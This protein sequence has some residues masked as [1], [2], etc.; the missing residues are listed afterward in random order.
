MLKVPNLKNISKKLWKELEKCWKKMLKKSFHSSKDFEAMKAGTGWAADILKIR[1]WMSHVW[2]S[3]RMRLHIKLANT[4]T[5]PHPPSGG[6]G[7][8]TKGAKTSSSSLTS[9]S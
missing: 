9:S 2:N 7:K 4:T 3:P 8:S 6:G 5:Q 1:S